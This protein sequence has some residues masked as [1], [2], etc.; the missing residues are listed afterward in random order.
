[1]KRIQK[2]EK[3]MKRALMGVKVQ[4]KQKEPNI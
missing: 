2:K 1:M 4:K 3:K